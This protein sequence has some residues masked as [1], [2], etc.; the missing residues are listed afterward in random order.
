MQ[1]RIVSR[2]EWLIARKQHLENEKALTRLRDKLSAERRALPW[3]RVE[4]AYVFDAPGGASRLV[5]IADLLPHELA[6]TIGAM[7]TQAMAVMKT[8]LERR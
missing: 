7:I 4:K 6:D 3:V 1:H 2:D 8:T 5:W